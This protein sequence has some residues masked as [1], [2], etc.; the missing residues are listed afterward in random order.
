M[1]FTSLKRISQSTENK[2]FLLQFEFSRIVSFANDYSTNS[3]KILLKKFFVNSGCKKRVNSF[4]LVN[5]VVS[6]TFLISYFELV[7]IIQKPQYRN[8]TYCFGT[9]AFNQIK[10]EQ[11]FCIPIENE[12]VRELLTGHFYVCIKAIKCSQLS[13]SCRWVIHPM[14]FW[15]LVH[16]TK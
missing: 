14:P 10:F 2:T 16:D 5:L 3:S 4:R 8:W 6:G 15:N 13:R 1:I 11:Q 9:T 12:S 7:S